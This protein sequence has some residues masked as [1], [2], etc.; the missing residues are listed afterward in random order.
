[1]VGCIRLLIIF[2]GG[3]FYFCLGN[4]KKRVLRRI[5]EVVGS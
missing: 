1:M 5:G 3:Y 2:G 4:I